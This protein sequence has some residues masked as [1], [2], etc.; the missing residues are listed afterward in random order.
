M[1]SGQ[2]GGQALIEC[3][4]CEQSKHRSGLCLE[5]DESYR[6]VDC[7]RVE[8]QHGETGHP[9]VLSEQYAVSAGVAVAGEPGVHQ[10]GTAKCGYG[11]VCARG[12]ELVPDPEGV[13]AVD[14][15]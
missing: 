15:C 7:L 2:S 3:Q 9:V 8:D 14:G 12:F 10:C 13:V 5:R 4:D 11:R 1:D 6:L